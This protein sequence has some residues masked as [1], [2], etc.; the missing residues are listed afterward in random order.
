MVQPVSS[1]NSSNSFGTQGVE[2]GSHADRVCVNFV[3]Q[4]KWRF[5]TFGLIEL[6]INKVP[7]FLNVFYHVEWNMEY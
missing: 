3:I 6:S 7:N 5:K 2:P 1:S 4:V